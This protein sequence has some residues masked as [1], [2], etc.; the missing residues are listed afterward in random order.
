MSRIQD[1]INQATEILHSQQEQIKKWEQLSKAQEWALKA[2]SH[3]LH[4]VCKRCAK[5]ATLTDDPEVIAEMW[6]IVAETE[7]LQADAQKAQDML[8]GVED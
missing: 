5:V 1:A 2:T 6:A 7:K 4:E 8:N 3:T